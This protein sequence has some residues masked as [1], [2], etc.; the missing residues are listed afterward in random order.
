VDKAASIT[1]TP[2][3]TTSKDSFDGSCRQQGMS[4]TYR[5][6]SIRVV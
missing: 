6:S 2:S 1:P 3:L 4:V 5:I